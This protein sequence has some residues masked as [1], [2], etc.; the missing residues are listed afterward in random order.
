MDTKA[1]WVGFNLVRGVG[2]VRL[3]NILD[4]FGNLEIAWNAPA[5]GLISAGIPARV[6]ENFLMIRKQVDLNVI[7]DRIETQGVKVLTWEDDSYPRRLK[8]ISQPPPVIFVRG[9]INV[10][11]DWAVSVVGTRRVTPYGRQVAM[12]IARFLAQNG[13][14]LVS[15]LAR[16]VDAIAHQAAMQE[17]GRTIAV[18]GSGV[19]VIYPPEH[20]KL[21]DEIMKQGAVISDYPLGT[22]PES[23]N[24]PPRNRIIA[25]LSLATIVVE[26]G[27]TSGA[28][29]TAEFAAEQGREVFAVPGSIL[30]PQSE[31]TNKLIE[32]G[33]RPLLRMNEILEILKLEQ[34]PEKQFT[35]KT[36]NAT[37]E[38]K[39]LLGYLNQ[40]P[41][42]IDEICQISGLPIQSVSATLT[43]MEL[44]GMV[45]Q[46]GGMNYVAAREVKAQYKV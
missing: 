11:D 8:E 44:K 38:E 34:I 35:R 41:K 42:H 40:D 7:M 25:G 26:A 46:V 10:E 9:S 16:G 17:G 2:A 39:K 36:I 31:G 15:G 6:V 20:R 32:E 5:E 27:E 22:Q 33:A 1:Y 29:I 14:T 21:A 30:T 18:L 23:S 43:M 28:L 24:F 37:S 19:D 12:E 13:V 45:T 4:H 3:K